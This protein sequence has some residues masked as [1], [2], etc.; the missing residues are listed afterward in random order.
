MR[1]RVF[2][3]G[4]L[5]ILG[6]RGTA[7]KFLIDEIQKGGCSSSGIEFLPLDGRSSCIT[8]LIF[9]LR[10]IH[11]GTGSLHGLLHQILWEGTGCGRS[12][13]LLG[14][15]RLVYRKTCHGSSEQEASVLPSLG[16]RVA[17]GT[18]GGRRSKLFGGRGRQGC[19]RGQRVLKS[20]FLTEFKYI[21]R[22]EASAFIFRAGRVVTEGTVVGWK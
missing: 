5:A 1:G 17:R 2:S 4:V 19:G 7:G 6:K 21:H 9:G 20:F 22:V 16:S 13:L 3:L 8:H 11:K 14:S 18:R 10:V 12:A 15:D